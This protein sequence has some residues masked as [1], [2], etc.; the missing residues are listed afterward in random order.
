MIDPSPQAQEPRP[1]APLPGVS[2]VLLFAVFVAYAAVGIPAQSL[3]VAWGLWFNEVFIFAG[4][5]LLVLRLAGRHA[6]RTTGLSGFSARALGVGFLF[7]AFNYA[8]W[9]VPLMAVSEPLFPRHLVELFSSAQVFKDRL[10]WEL[11]AIVV[12]VAVAAPLCEELFFRG[13]LQQGLTRW[14][15]GPRAVVV[16]ALVFSAFHFDPVG[17]LARF[18]LGVLFGLLCWRSGSLW[19]GIG[20]HAANNL[21]STAG[22][23]ALQ[24][25]SETDLPVELVLGGAVVGNLLLAGLLLAVRRWPTLLAAPVQAEDTPAPSPGVWRVAAPWLLGAVA[26][27]AVLAAVDF[28][29]VV[30]SVY[31]SRF[32]A[33]SPSRTASDPE[34]AA[35][36]EL[37]ALRKKARAG[38][39]PLDEYFALRRLAAE[40]E[41]GSAH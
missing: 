4:L 40:G 14:L 37:T 21:V 34:K 8:A 16:T 23:F 19:A 26:A 2:G 1:P 22:W 9:A 15:E 32:P 17:F 24:G 5:P 38:E 12:G 35:W 3:N 30:L 10:P 6:R 31:D 33:K 25:G 13:V 28:N 27:M 36:A 39:V 18:E 41:A 20:A 11:G 29:G 7:G